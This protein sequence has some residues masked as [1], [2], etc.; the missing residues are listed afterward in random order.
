MEKRISAFE[1]F[2]QTF[3]SNLPSSSSY[4]QAYERTEHT[5]KNM[6][7]FTPYSGYDSFRTFRQRKLK[8]RKKR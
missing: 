4:A 2:N 8:A 3:E 5:F 1:L 6:I 7:G